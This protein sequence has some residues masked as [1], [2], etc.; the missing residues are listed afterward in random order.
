MHSPMRDAR[1]KGLNLREECRNMNV[2]LLE[3][4]GWEEDL[5]SHGD[6]SSFVPDFM[7]HRRLCFMP[8]I[9]TLPQSQSGEYYDSSS[10]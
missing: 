5:C 8:L 9:C 1:K 4:Y 3:I 7:Q 6:E 2:E 10:H